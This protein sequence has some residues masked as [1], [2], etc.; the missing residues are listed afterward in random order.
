MR[1]TAVTVGVA[2]VCAVVGAAMTA[3]IVIFGARYIDEHGDE[4]EY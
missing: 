3:A 2:T 1:R 4:L